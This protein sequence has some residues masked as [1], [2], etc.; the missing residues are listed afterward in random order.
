VVVAYGSNE[1][2]EFK[3]QAIDFHA[4]LQ[5]AGRHAEVVVAEGMN[6]FEISTTLARSDG[7]LAQAMLKLM[8]LT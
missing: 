2:P 6:H 4:A 8:G 3:R 7:L 1:S 5:T